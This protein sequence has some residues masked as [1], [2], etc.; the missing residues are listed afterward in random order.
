MRGPIPTFEALKNGE[1]VEVEEA[2]HSEYHQREYHLGVTKSDRG[3]DACERKMD[4]LDEF[5]DIGIKEGRQIYV[6]LKG[7]RYVIA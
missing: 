4:R 6:R 1:A 2:W 7:G 3:A 5:K